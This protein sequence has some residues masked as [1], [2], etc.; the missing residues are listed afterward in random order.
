MSSAR[1]TI[2]I[3]LADD[4]PVVREGLKALIAAQ[5]DLEVVGE[6]NDGRA[7]LPLAVALKPD[8]IVMDLTMPGLGGAEAT[9]RLR[10]TLPEAKVLALTVH[11]ERGYFRR[12]FEAGAR[13]YALKQSPAEVLFQAIRVVASGEIY[14]DPA[15]T[16]KVVSRL[17]R[18]DP[19]KLAL[20]SDPLSER[21]SEVVRLIARGFTNKEIA[22][23]LS[24]NA[25]TVETYKARSL[26]KLS[27]RSRA[28]LVRYALQQG[29][30][31]AT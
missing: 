15:L 9:E 5:P 29:W 3:L 28:D 20:G 1:S 24:I 26:E 27:L 8:V 16:G 11:E 6:A 10:E 13:G 23:R 30:L 12:L 4:H 18:N 7:V 2:R 19:S 22:T 17:V 25:K 31:D 14:L 21:E